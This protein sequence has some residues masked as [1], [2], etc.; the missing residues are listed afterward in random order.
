[1][2]DYEPLPHVL[3]IGGPAGAGKTIVARRL[4]RRYGLRWYNC[5][6]QTWRHLDRALAIGIR[7]AQRFGALTPAQRAAAPAAEIEYDRGPFTIED[8]RALPSAPLIVVDGAP[9]APTVAA[10][11]QAVWLL[12]SRAVQRTRLAARHPDG[13][14]P[15]YLQQWQEVA[16]R[17]AASGQP[18]VTVDG[19]TVEQTVAEVARVFANRLAAG[20]V[21]TTMA[22]RRQLLR[23]ANTEIIAQCQGWFA[24]QP[25]P[26]AGSLRAVSTASAAGPAASNWSSCRSKW[27]RRRSRPA[28][29]SPPPATEPGCPRGDR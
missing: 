29:P 4:A 15:R 2:P 19:L 5:D 11:G 21:A 26:A 25:D 3:W 10:E 20:P 6:A 28:P 16:D 9:P 12:P 1:M 23:Y 7:N 14:P 18:S 27:P 17:A 8:L 22:E 24:H 13:I